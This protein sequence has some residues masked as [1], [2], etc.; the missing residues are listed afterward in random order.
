VATESIPKKE[1]GAAV[2][3]SVLVSGAGVLEGLANADVCGASTVE[4]EAFSN[5][6]VAASEGGETR[7]CVA[8]FATTKHDALRFA[9]SRHVEFGEPVCETTPENKRKNE[10]NGLETNQI[11]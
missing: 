9:S 11:G 1:N 7:P 8:A 10:S 4:N 2:M 5:A 3:E 6:A